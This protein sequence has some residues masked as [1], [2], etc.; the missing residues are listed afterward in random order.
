[1]TTDAPKPPAKKDIM[2]AFQMTKK[3]A[4]SSYDQWLYRYNHLRAEVVVDRFSK[5]KKQPTVQQAS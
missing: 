4:K 3:A 5:M 2:V 1:M